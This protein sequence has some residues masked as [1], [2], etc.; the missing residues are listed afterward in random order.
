MSGAHLKPARSRLGYYDRDLPVVPPGAG[1]RA[2]A[3][4]TLDEWVEA[5]IAHRTDWAKHTTQRNCRHY[6]KGARWRDHC[7]ALGVTRAD[8]LTT[9][10]VEA[11]LAEQRG[12]VSGD[13][14]IKFRTYFRALAAHQRDVAGF[15]DGLADLGRVRKPKGSGRRKPPALSKDEE[16]AL[17]EAAVGR[18]QLLVEFLL[19]TGVRVSELCG[20]HL[21]HLQLEARIPFVHVVGSV[22]DLDTTKGEED[23]DVPFRPLY[24]TLPARLRAYL[25]ER[26]DTRQELFLS[27]KPDAQGRPAPLTVSGVQ[28]VCGRLSQRVGFHVHPHLL[29]HTWATRLVDAGMGMFHL[30]QAGGWKSLE[31]VRVYYRADTREMLEAF[32]RLR[33]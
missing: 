11:F 7:A 9:D 23:R 2:G 20:L 5:L 19:A 15:G 6:L 24:R 29:R 27:T 14:L 30:R 21:A 8:Q 10:H 25:A 16:R 32:H 22:H 3:S 1:R 18:D 31:M 4:P 17:V 33:E 12:L 26:T 28:Q 13:Y